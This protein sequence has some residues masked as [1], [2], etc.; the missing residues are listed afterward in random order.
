MDSSEL[1]APSSDDDDDSVESFP[2]LVFKE[3]DEE[4][5]SDDEAEISSSSLCRFMLLESGDGLVLFFST[6]LG[7]WGDGTIGWGEGVFAI[8]TGLGDV[9]VVVIEELVSVS[10]VRVDDD[11]DD[12]VSEERDVDVLDLLDSDIK[13]KKVSH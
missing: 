4:D 2:L 11:D 1:L 3:D 10:V 9:D 13:I 8:E 7:R 5:V 6:G 12:D